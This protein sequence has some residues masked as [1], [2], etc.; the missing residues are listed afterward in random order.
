MS[1]LDDSSN[2]VKVA[3]MSICRVNEA[4]YQWLSLY[5]IKRLGY[6]REEIIRRRE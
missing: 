3:F 5:P 4:F 6:G 1:D 2:S